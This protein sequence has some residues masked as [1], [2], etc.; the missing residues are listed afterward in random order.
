[1]KLIVV[2]YIKYQI[3][4]AMIHTVHVNASCAVILRYNT[5]TNKDC[6]LLKLKIESE[7]Q[8]SDARGCRTD[9]MIIV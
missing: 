6:T 5:K 3:S 4:V 1:M 2:F 9:F 7:V 8:G